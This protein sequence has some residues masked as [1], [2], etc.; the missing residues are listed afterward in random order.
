MIRSNGSNSDHTCFFDDC[1]WGE[2]G[3]HTAKMFFTLTE[4]EQFGGVVVY[5]LLCKSF[6]G[7]TFFFPQTHVQCLYSFSVCACLHKE[8]GNTHNKQMIHRHLP[9]QPHAVHRSE[10]PKCDSSL[11]ELGQVKTIISRRD[12][13][14]YS[15]LHLCVAASLSFVCRSR[16]ILNNSAS[17]NTPPGGAAVSL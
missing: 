13:A 7:P 10:T 8:A 17:G 6:P 16:F 5:R 1:L 9:T 3:R 15:S 2:S 12:T 4:R 11:C 14:V